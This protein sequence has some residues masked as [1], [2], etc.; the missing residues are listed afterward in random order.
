[1]PPR[2]AE[3]EVGNAY[4]PA[5]ARLLLESYRR[6]T[7]ADLL[8][9]ESASAE[10]LYTA[11]FVVVSHCTDADP[12]FTYAN[13]SAQQAFEMPWAEIVGMPSRF[14]AE[15]LLREERQ[16]LLDRVT[17]DG[18]IDDYCGIR[19]AKSGRRFHVRNATVWNLIDEA[20]KVVGQAATFAEWQ[21]VED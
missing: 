20:G 2:E 4:Y 5:H 21:P 16:R 6:L 17:R 19:I 12:K 7:G 8:P 1:M 14:S 15:P 9:P 11:P 10:A 3:P 13:R 18:F